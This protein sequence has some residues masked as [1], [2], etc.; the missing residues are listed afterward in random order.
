MQLKTP[1]QYLYKESL[2]C[3]QPFIWLLVLGIAAY[4]WYAVFNQI[5]LDHPAGSN[6]APDIMLILIWIIFGILLPFGLYKSRLTIKLNSR[7]LTYRFIPFHLNEHS[8]PI[9]GIKNIEPVTIRPILQFGG[10]GIRYGLKG[11]GYILR[12][13]KGIKVSF[14]DGRPVYFSAKN[15]DSIVDAFRKAIT[16]QRV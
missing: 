7:Q 6:P 14:K 2:Y 16:Q 4:T 15:A 11:K 12:G 8:Y 5:I 3:K 13:G 1:S 10:W 9:G